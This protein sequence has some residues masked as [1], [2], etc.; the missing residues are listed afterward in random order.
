MSPNEA[1][2]HGICRKMGGTGD[3]HA[4]QNKPD[5][6]SQELHIFSCIWNP[7]ERK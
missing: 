1:Q 3:H 6:E 4:K 7:G 5:S 2:N